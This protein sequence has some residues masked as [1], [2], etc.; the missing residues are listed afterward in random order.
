M[1]KL[2]M[3]KQKGKELAQKGKEIWD[4]NK[5]FIGIVGGAVLYAVAERTWNKYRVGTYDH[6][7]KVDTYIMPGT[8]RTFAVDKKT[9]Y[10]DRFGRLMDVKYGNYTEEQAEVNIKLMQDAL[11]DWREREY[12]G[13]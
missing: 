4:K 6:P 3:A 2:E 13:D 1:K 9:E 5:V 8:G 11:N 12:P 10:Y 7:S